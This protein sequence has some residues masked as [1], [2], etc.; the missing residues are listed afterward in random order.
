MAFH[1]QYTYYVKL[2]G[3]GVTLDGAL[4]TI[5]YSHASHAKAMMFIV[6][7]QVVVLWIHCA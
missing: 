1:G 5:T 6:H 4:V 3:L 7:V 2:V